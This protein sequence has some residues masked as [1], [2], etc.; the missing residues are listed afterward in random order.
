MP[1]PTSHAR[2]ASR[3]IRP[4]R[5]WLRRFMFAFWR[6]VRAILIGGAMAGPCPPPPPEPPPQTI[7]ATVGDEASTPPPL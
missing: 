4:M 6:V 3:A 1:S 7:E 5:R 2:P